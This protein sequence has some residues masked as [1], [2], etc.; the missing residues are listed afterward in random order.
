MP[1]L[2]ALKRS[3]RYELIRAGLEGT[4]LALKLGL[5]LAKPQRGVIFALHHVDPESP[6]NWVPNAWLSIT[7]TFLEQAIQ[8][9][10]EQGLTPLAL[11]DLPERLA[12]RR[13]TRRYVCF[14][15]DDGYRDNARFAAP[16]FRRHA[17]PYTIFITPGFV[18]RTRSIWWKTAEALVMNTDDVDLSVFGIDSRVD[19]RHRAERVALFD[20]LANAI[21]DAEDEDATI[22]RLDTLVK[23]HGIDPLEITER[24]TMDARELAALAADPLARFGA[25]T[26]THTNLTKVDDKRLHTELTQSASKV[27]G[28]VG[29]KP[30]TFAYPYGFASAVG[31]REIAA[32]REAG[33]I[34]A[35]TTR[36]G[37]L[38]ETCSKAATALPR[39]SLNGFYQRKRYVLALLS[40]LPFRFRKS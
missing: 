25:H 37:L 2:Q 11:E 33:F 5:P 20:R 39:V 16:V 31:A 14:T 15:L 36:P 30:T 22:T 34:A 8:L 35:V 40:G 28:Y 27:C 1:S 18:E 29:T 24:L 38:S 10:R 4:A 26:L 13:D 21:N 9:C 17:V 23:A 12:D 6:A 32:A 3:A 7:P 19:I